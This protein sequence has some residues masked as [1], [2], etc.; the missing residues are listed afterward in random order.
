ML[1]KLMFH[2][3]IMIAFLSCA[4][5]KPTGKTEAE[6][7][8]KEAKELMDDGRYI[9]ATE[10]LNQLKNQYPYS[11]YATPAELMQADI[12]FKQENFVDAAAAYL[13]FRDFHPKHADI[14]YVVYRIAESY[15]MQKPETFD[16]DLVGAVEAIKYYKELIDKYP[17]S[18]HVKDAN[19]KI[20]ECEKM[21][22][23]KEQY[24]ADFYF[25][26]ELY[27]AARWRYLEIINQFDNK[28]LKQH[29]I[30]R[31]VES[32]LKLKEYE[33]CI[34]YADTYLDILGNQGKKEVE[35]IK[36]KCK[37]SIQ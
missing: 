24:I 5:D 31:V 14:P 21:I 2:I 3:F 10:K 7:L 4:S 23:D 8:F 22:Q 32:S 37:K 16:R 34:N 27:S 15:Y 17:S 13:L 11:F 35:E 29:S 9:L 6:V 19:S 26:T 20:A 25:K 33:K 12:L 1:L 30:K 18:E 36:N 28:Q